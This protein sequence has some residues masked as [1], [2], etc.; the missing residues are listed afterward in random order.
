MASLTE[1]LVNAF[2]RSVATVD[3]SSGQS[4]AGYRFAAIRRAEEFLRENMDTPFSSRGLCAATRMSERSIE[5]LFKEA[6]GV[7]PRAWSQIARL[8]AAR[9]DLVEG[10]TEEVRVSN[11]AV[12]WG[13]LHFGRFSAS[14]RNLFGELPSATVAKKR[15]RKRP[16]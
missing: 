6:Y 9:Q 16:F 13:F 10:H 2:V 11:V 5:M 3:R 8:N 7:S 15:R 1:E 4:F 12:R 14:Y